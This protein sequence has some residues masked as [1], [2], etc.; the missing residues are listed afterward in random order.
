M[1]VDTPNPAVGA[2]INYIISVTNAGPNNATSVQVND[3]LPSGVT[4]VGNT[5]DQGTY[6]PLTGIWAVGTVNSGSL[7]IITI[8]VTVDLGTSGMTITNNASV[9]SALTDPTPGNNATSVD[10]IVM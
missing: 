10:I 7:V 8:Q 6:T 9:S 3:L 5:A 4:Y 1:I 2:T